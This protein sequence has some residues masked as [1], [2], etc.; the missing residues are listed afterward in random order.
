VAT[1]SLAAC[2]RRESAA[3]LALLAVALATFLVGIFRPFS[4]VTKLWIFETEVSVWS[5][6]ITLRQEGE[7]FLFWVILVFTVVF[8]LTKMLSLA[9]LWLAP[10]LSRARMLTLHRFVGHLGKWSMLDVFIVAMLVVYLK[11]GS[12]A[13]ITIRDGIVV[14]TFSVVLTQC[15]SLWIGRVA[16]RHIEE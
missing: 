2:Y 11:S 15:T 13:D 8:P 12:F 5:S 16:E 3:I 7:W 10:G 6:L 4:M 1:R 9:V 14:F